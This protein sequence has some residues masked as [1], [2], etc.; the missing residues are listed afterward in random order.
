MSLV[1]RRLRRAALAA[2]CLAAAIPADAS[3]SAAP[4]LRVSGPYVY[5]NLDVYLLHGAEGERG[6]RLTPLSRALSEKKVVVRETGSVNQLTVENVSDDEVFLQAGDIVKGGKQDR[7]LGTDLVLPPKSGQVKVAA[8]CVEHGRWTRR[9]VEAADRFASSQ[10]HASDKALKLANHKGS[11]G[12]V[13]ANVDKVQRKL[14]GNVGADVRSRESASSLQLTLEHE[15]VRKSVEGYVKALSDLVASHPD[16]VGYAF[17]IN[18]E[19]NSAEVYGARALFVELWPKLLHASAVEAVAERKPGTP[20][21]PPTLDNVRAF[22]SD[23]DS[24]AGAERAAGAAT[25]STA[26]ETERTLLVETRTGRSRT[27]VHKSYVSK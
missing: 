25:R 22:L 6:R 8:H 13:W 16:A 11:Q 18:G 1:S 21:T 10:A 27:W 17:A 23:A 5:E 24:A 19:M 12:E 7:V 4:E 26:R 3:P 20:H 9:G 15:R 2:T 14:Q